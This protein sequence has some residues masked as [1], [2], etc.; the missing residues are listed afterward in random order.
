M[1]DADVPVLR[2]DRADG[3]PPATPVHADQPAFVLRHAGE[4]LRLSWSATAGL[5]RPLRL[6]V[7][8]ARELWGATDL[9]VTARR[10][11]IGRATLDHVDAFEHV[12]VPLHPS[13]P[14]ELEGGVV[15]SLDGPETVEL[16]GV[17]AGE[18]G[19]LGPR[20]LGAEPASAGSRRRL[21][22]GI[23][24]PS[25]I[26]A[27][28]WKLGC[29]LD[30]LLDLA[31]ATGERRFER[32]GRA[33]LDEFV[34]DGGA[35]AYHDPWG[36]AVAGGIYGIEG[37]L[38]LAAMARLG[39]A[40]L[41]RELCEE[42]LPRFRRA[43]GAVR[44]NGMLS[45]EGMYTVA[46]PLAVIGALSG[47]VDYLADARRQLRLRVAALRDGGVLLRRYEDGRVEFRDWIRAWTWYLLGLAR[48]LPILESAGVEV[49]GLRSELA[50]IAE[51][52]LRWRSEDDLWHTYVDDPATPLETS[53]SAGIAAAW[54]IGAGH[55]LLDADWSDRAARTAE[56]LL[57]CVGPE[58]VLRGASQANKDGERLQRSRYRINSQVGSGLLA[59][60]C[61]ALLA[62]GR[63]AEV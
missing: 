36:R 51:A 41:A 55:G 39:R 8:I 1:P 38:P 15:L 42:F 25:S 43:D 26:Q 48:T 28:G 56:A 9:V 3:R 12:D 18:S 17:G 31:E 58:G 63:S 52:S 44:D 61:A 46:Y 22:D 57:A 34:D 59:Q 7:T 5:A 49:A 13:E 27:F 16:F 29:V 6:R 30:G 20:L 10:G 40:T 50:E 62:Y 35:L 4:P 2:P 37:L 47:R 19:F 45:A 53:G 33:H 60:L 23:A 24:S 11:E 32:R 21:L 14:D 54:A